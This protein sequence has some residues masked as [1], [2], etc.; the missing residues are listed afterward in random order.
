MAQRHR[1][2]ALKEMVFDGSDEC[3]LTMYLFPQV[4]EWCPRNNPFRAV[5]GTLKVIP[6]PLGI[7]LARPYIS[8]SIPS[9]FLPPT[10]SCLPADC[11]APRSVVKV[12]CECREI[13]CLRTSMS[14]LQDLTRNQDRYWSNSINAKARPS[15]LEQSD[16]KN[17]GL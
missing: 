10:Q 15:I 11:T 1:C 8:I 17:S 2:L 4:L 12:C 3:M 13:R 5:L 7:M 6:K 14:T 9:V 16:L